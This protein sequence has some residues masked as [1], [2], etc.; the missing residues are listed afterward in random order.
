MPP[1]K[2]E[3]GEPEATCGCQENLRVRLILVVMTQ[4]GNRQHRIVA[5]FRGM[6]PGEEAEG[7]AGAGLQQDRVF[8]LP[9]SLQSVMKAGRVIGVAGPVVRVGGL[10]DGNP[11]TRDIRDERD[12]RRVKAN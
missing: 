11:P 1:A 6:L 9:E 12:T 10:R 7:L 8:D 2:I 4:A 5:R 3:P